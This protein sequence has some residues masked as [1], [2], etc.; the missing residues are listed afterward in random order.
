MIYIL[1]FF[2]LNQTP[3][4]LGTFDNLAGCEKAIRTIFE[5]ELTPVGV[6]LTQDQKDR[7]KFI[8]DSKLKLQREYRCIPKG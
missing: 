6:T 3:A 8:I 2:G 7:N 1:M 5:T 4:Q